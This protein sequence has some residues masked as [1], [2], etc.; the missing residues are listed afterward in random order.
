[1]P[2]EAIWGLGTLLQL[3]D[4]VGNYTTVAEV[5]DYPGPQR[6]RDR[7]DITN[8]S[9][10]GGYEEML[11]TIKRTGEM[12]FNVNWNPD[13]HATHVD[14]W[15]LYDSG[16]LAPFRIVGPSSEFTISF[17]ARVQG[18]QPTFPINAQITSQITLKPSGPVTLT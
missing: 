12:S 5:Q 15:D 1:M 8:H 7:A 4:G 13:A 11:M 9:S 3:G 6:Q 10:T 14:L 2:S 17:E 18:D 16:E